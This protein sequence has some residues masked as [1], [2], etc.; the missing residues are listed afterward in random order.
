MRCWEYLRQSQGV[1]DT[2]TG[3][4]AFSLSPVELFSGPQILKNIYKSCSCYK[5]E[6]YHTS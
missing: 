4:W 5:S 3:A 1:V 2:C 6:I